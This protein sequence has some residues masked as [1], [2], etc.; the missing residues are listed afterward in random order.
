MRTSR[1]CMETV[2]KV[3]V[4]VVVVV[5]KVVVVVV[6]KVGRDEEGEGE[7]PGRAVR[8]SAKPAD[9]RALLGSGNTDDHFRLGIKV[10]RGAI[11]LFSDLYQSDIIVASPLALA[12][13]LAVAAEP[14][15]VLLA[16]TEDASSTASARAAA[17]QARS[18]GSAGDMVSD[19]LSSIEV[20][21][22]DRADVMTMQNWAH[23]EAVVEA[24]NRTPREQHGTDIMRVREWA[25]AGWAR[26]YRQTV[27][28]SS[29]IS[30]AMSALM[31]GP[32]TANHSGRLRLKPVPRGVLGLVVPQVQ[33][34]YER[35]VADS[36]VAAVDAR[37]KYF[38]NIV[39]PRVR[40]SASFG[41][42]GLL[43]FV[44]SY[45][46]FVRIRNF[47]RA[48]DNDMFETVCEYTA[49][50]DVTAARS[51][52]FTRRAKVLVYTE[53]AHFYFRHRMRGVKDVLFYAPPEHPAFYPDLLNLLED[54]GSSRQGP[55]AGGSH[56]SVTLLFCRWD[57][58]ALERLV[59][60]KRAKRM[61]SA[62]TNTFMFY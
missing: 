6:V 21:V 26:H 1:V 24:L 44:P 18:A 35:F 45:F 37:F 54:A 28:L 52:F 59:G 56:S 47:L 15:V 4:V 34:V 7:D 3:V 61:L 62:D 12:T 27:L 57:V 32:L 38:T 30:P 20:L 55:K 51:R 60:T 9:W 40:D 29:F 22:I 31:S 53:R 14:A 10:T 11:R 13:K 16:G 58:L 46:D 2:V 39:W 33:Q 25:L 8:R 42:G 19:F 43:L 36:P 48:E 17:K 5:V 23:V 41:S 50:P 49:H